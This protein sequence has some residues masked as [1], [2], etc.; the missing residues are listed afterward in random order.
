MISLTSGSSISDR[1]PKP[2][3]VVSSPTTTAVQPSASKILNKPFLTSIRKYVSGNRLR[4]EDSEF[5]LD[6]TYV[7]DRIIAMSFP[8]VGIEGVYRNP[9]QQVRQY[10]DKHHPEKYLVFNLC[11]EQRY[12]YD[13]RDFAHS[14]AIEGVVNIPV[15]KNTTPPLYQIGSFCQQAMN[16]LAQ[17]ESNVVVVHCLRGTGRTGVMLSALL[18]ALRVTE[19]AAEAIELFNHQRGGKDL[20][21]SMGSQTRWVHLFGELLALST[22]SVPIS[23]AALGQAARYTWTLESIQLGPTRAL[24]QSISVRPRSAD[25]EQILTL[26]ELFKQ[27]MRAG[28]MARSVCD[29]VSVD[30]AQSANFSNS[31]DCVFSIRLKKGASSSTVSF[32]F[33]GEMSQ[34]MINH[35]CSD[36]EGRYALILNAPDLDSPSDPDKSLGCSDVGFFVK[37]HVKFSKVH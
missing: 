2:T 24:V 23:I 33:C 15:R 8:A 10:L 9:R 5:N 34:T 18:L 28:I 27:R 4:I 26:P 36:K 3:P 7:T 13:V 37:V 31:E 19:S 20:A 30:L 35:R 29:V 21:L 22:N 32:W 14:L 17:D 16:W 11:G 1:P 6:M 25:K 12:Q